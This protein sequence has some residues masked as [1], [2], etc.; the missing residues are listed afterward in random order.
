MPKRSAG[1]IIG[2]LLVIAG[3]YLVTVYNGLVRKEETV[4][5]QWNEVQNTYQRRLDLIPNLVSV[6]RG[7]ADFE[8][9]TLTKVAQARSAASGAVTAANVNR[10]LTAQNEVATSVNQMLARVENYP[11]LKGTQAFRDLQVQLEGTERRIK[12]ARKDFNTSVQDYNNSVRSFPTNMV[13]G[14]FGFQ[15]KD[16]FAAGS[17]AENAVEIKF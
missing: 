7:G 11:Q 8:S 1:Y 15:A 13:A 10:Q 9:T 17:G 14:M 2:A 16:G 3:I 12:I 4:N 6:V 5:K